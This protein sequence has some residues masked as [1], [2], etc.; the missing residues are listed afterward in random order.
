MRLKPNR[1][2]FDEVKQLKDTER[3]RDREIEGERKRERE[4]DRES[5][6]AKHGLI[7]TI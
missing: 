2:S 1:I 3:D 7:C 5:D 6:E 4:R